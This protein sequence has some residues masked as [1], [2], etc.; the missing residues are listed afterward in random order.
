MRVHISFS[1]Y[2]FLQRFLHSLFTV[3]EHNDEE[4]SDY[5]LSLLRVIE[6]TE[7]QLGT[8]LFHRQRH[9]EAHLG[10]IVCCISSN[11]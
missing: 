5:F 11:F 2:T 10:N 9:L 8:M 6:H 4:Y 7:K 1:S 3:V